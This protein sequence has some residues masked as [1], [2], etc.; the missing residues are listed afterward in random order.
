MDGDPEHFITFFYVDQAFTISGD[1][2]GIQ[3]NNVNLQPGWNTIHYYRSEYPTLEEAWTLVTDYSN[4]QWTLSD[5][6]EILTAHQGTWN[7]VDRTGVTISVEPSQITI[8]GAGSSDIN[9]TFIL[10]RMR[11]QG[12]SWIYSF[13]YYEWVFTLNNG[14][15]VVDNNSGPGSGSLSGTYRK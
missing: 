8:S 9:R 7:G 5:E 1:F 6:I 4:F 2:D 14:N 3:M 13:S 15:L 10:T 11:Q 12:E